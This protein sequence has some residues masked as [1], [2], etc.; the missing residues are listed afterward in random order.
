MI[1]Y[2]PHVTPYDSLL[3]VGEQSKNE[4]NINSNS[5]FID[6]TALETVSTSDK[7]NH[8]PSQEISTPHSQYHE[9]VVIYVNSIIE[10]V[11]CR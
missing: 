9:S 11:A 1:A 7:S 8:A 10:S 4:K 3:V 5:T 2:K 6:N